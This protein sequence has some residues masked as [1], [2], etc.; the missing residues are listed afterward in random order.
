MSPQIE[1][2]IS[3]LI[4]SWIFHIRTPQFG[5]DVGLKFY[6]L[7]QSLSQWSGLGQSIWCCIHY[8]ILGFN[9]AVIKHLH[10]QFNPK[11]R[12][13]NNSIG[14]LSAREDSHLQPALFLAWFIHIEKL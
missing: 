12:V 3:C 14:L 13:E 2:N 7:H 1:Y 10:H 4:D 6:V 8:I 5:Y 9:T 11:K